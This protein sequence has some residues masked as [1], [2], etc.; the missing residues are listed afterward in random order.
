MKQFQKWLKEDSIKTGYFYDDVAEKQ[1]E[2]A[3]R[4]ALELVMSRIK[5][6]SEVA[7]SADDVLMAVKKEIREEL[8]DEKI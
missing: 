5:F 7:Y 2:K 8:E 4:A 3:W 6:G 1:R